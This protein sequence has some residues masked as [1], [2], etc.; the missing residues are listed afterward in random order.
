MMVQKKIFLTK[1]K[2][3][4][5]LFVTANFFIA[6]IEI[7]KKILRGLRIYFFT[8][9]FSLKACSLQA[10]LTVFLAPC[11]KFIMHTYT[12]VAFVQVRTMNSWLLRCILFVF[13]KKR[14]PFTSKLN[15]Y[16]PVSLTNQP[17]KT[18]MCCKISAFL[19]ALFNIT[20]Y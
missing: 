7:K 9:E 15:C 6:I 11:Y 20:T 17:L 18:G 14:Q 4:P 8:D 12:N 16:P 3:H 13:C 10:Y 5:N 1:L 19:T 2:G